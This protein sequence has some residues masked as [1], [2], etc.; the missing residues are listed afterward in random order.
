MSDRSKGRV[1][2]WLFTTA[3]ATTGAALTWGLGPAL[4]TAGCCMAGF[5]IAVDMYP[6]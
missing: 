4:L 1:A 5:A 2:W 6:R 3:I